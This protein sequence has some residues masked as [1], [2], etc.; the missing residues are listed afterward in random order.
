MDQTL[1]NLY[2]SVVDQAK[3]VLQVENKNWPSYVRSEFA[4]LRQA[5][6]NVK[7]R[8][9]YLNQVTQELLDR[10]IKVSVAK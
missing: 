10:P 4:D 6:D 3:K 7:V 2:Q 8:Q 5:V 1:V 9:M